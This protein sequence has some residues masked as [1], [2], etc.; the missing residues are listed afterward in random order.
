MSTT[1]SIDDYAAIAARLNEIEGRPSLAE[2]CDALR[3]RTRQM[4]AENAIRREALEALADPRHSHAG[5]IGMGAMVKVACP[6]CMDT[7]W[8]RRREDYGQRIVEEQCPR[9]FNP[10]GYPPPGCRP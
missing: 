9:C 8:T 2:Q 1:S 6:M 7:G 5:G 10:R 4:E 3:N